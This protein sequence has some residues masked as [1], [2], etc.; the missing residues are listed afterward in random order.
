MQILFSN[1][2]KKNDH[3]KHLDIFFS[4]KNPLI[5]ND[6]N[7]IISLLDNISK[8]WT[9]GN[10][11]IRKIFNENSLGFIIPWLNKKNSIRML[12]MS[13]VNYNFLNDPV[14][15]KKKNTKMFARPKGTVLHW[16]AGNV[17]VITFISL[18]QGILTKN[19]N[20]IKVSKM[21]KKLIPLI[22]EDLKKNIKLKK[23]EKNI[24]EN[25]L[26]SLIII[27]VDHY[28]KDNL[29]YLSKNSDTR[30]IWGG[31]ESVSK[32]SKLPKK[33]G[34]NDIIFGPK[35]SLSYISSSKIKSNYDIKK[36]ADLFVN[37]V[38][39]FDQLGCNSPHNLMI[40]GASKKKL[41]YISKKL[42][43]VFR[44]RLLNI[45][46]ITDPVKKYNVLVKNFE[47]TLTEGNIS[48]H[49]ENFEWN[50]YI[51][52]KPKINEPLY[53]RSIFLSSVKSFKDLKK[54]LPINT[55]SIGLFTN[56]EE[57]NK[58]IKELSYD[59]VDRFPEIGSMSLYD[60]PWD[61]YLPLQNLVRWISY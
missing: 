42:S 36:F 15:Y 53:N 23:N 41:I 28:E 18:F 4:K 8:Y 60:Y 12:E 7:Q 57:R 9:F 27:Y 59:R 5:D 52:N 49:D 30:I 26:D 34:C 6:I 13:F 10:S 24:F 51:N 55:Q 29:D 22:F 50:I 56:N 58:I 43:N 20:I 45:N 54:I 17:P 44:N 37:D 39:N 61:G 40:E 1:N 19:K 25:I 47:F 16:L 2:N 48:F 38:F 3:K 14:M 31:E 11:K 32:I 33:I 21:Y 46:S 35:V